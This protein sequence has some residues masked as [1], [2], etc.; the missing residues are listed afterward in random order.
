MICEPWVLTPRAAHGN[1]RHM[2]KTSTTR[3]KFGELVDS[4]GRRITW[5]ARS[6]GVDPSVVSGWCSG[7]R[8]VPRQRI[9]EL[10]QLLGVPEE[11]LR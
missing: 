9:T 6:V 2:P 11:S 10:A 7:Y 3:T 1:M 4:Q 5:I 8:P